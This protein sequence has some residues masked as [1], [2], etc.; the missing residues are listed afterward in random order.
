VKPANILLDASRAPKLTDFDLVAAKD[1]TGGTRTGAMGTFLFTA[2]EQMQK[3]KEAD[4]RADI[5]GLGMTTIFCIHGGE[6]PETT[7]RRPEEVITRLSCNDAIKGVLIQAI[8]MK[9]ND[10]FV[11]ALEF[12]RA[13]RAAAEPLATSAA[14]II[15]GD[16]NVASGSTK[17]GS[18]LPHP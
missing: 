1:T 15:N 17:K 2:P 13:L 16:A 10:R 7:L 4:P 12:C 14:L 3:A 9:P 5:Y 8:E 11:S 6:L 18:R